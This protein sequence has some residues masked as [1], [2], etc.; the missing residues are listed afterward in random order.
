MIS[1]V[2]KKKNWVFQIPSEWQRW[3]G[4]SCPCGC[5]TA[6]GASSAWTAW[7]GIT[8]AP[9]VCSRPGAVTGL[10]ELPLALSHGRD[11]AADP[12]STVIG[13]GPGLPRRPP[14]PL[15]GD[16]GH[17][18]AMAGLRGP[19]Q[20]LTSRIAHLRP[21]EINANADIEFCHRIINDNRVSSSENSGLP[22]K[23]LYLSLLA[24]LEI[25]LEKVHAWGAWVAPCVKPLP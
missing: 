3:P 4:S 13:R 17:V 11:Q 6:G 19:P 24:Y 8:G 25:P 15:W 10:A 22:N 1:Q 5:V 14:P 9:T 12:H 23:D 21:C 20:R 7:S 16:A 18:R 2:L